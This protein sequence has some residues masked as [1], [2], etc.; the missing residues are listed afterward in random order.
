MAILE[1]AAYQFEIPLS[2]ASDSQGIR[3]ATEAGYEFRDASLVAVEKIYRLFCLRSATG[4]YLGMRSPTF[5][6][7]ADC[8][9]PRIK[10]GT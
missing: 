1:E 8:P 9:D 3:K 7:L 5:S 4:P 10:H 2:K 6:T